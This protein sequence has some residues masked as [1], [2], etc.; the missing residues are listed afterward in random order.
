[1]RTS[2]AAPLN[3]TTT[4]IIEDFA[5]NGSLNMHFASNTSITPLGVR[6]LNVSRAKLEALD[7]PIGTREPENALHRGVLVREAVRSAWASV[8]SNNTSQLTDWRSTNALGL[9][10]VTEE[11]EE[12]FDSDMAEERWL[13][14]VLANVEQADEPYW[15]EATVGTPDYED[16]DYEY[17]EAESYTFPSRA[18]GADVTVVAVSDLDADDEYVDSWL[19]LDESTWQVKAPQY[20]TRSEEEDLPELSPPS[21]ST[22]SSSSLPTPSPRPVLLERAAYEA[23]SPPKKTLYV[24]ED[25]HIVFD[26][27][28][29]SY[30]DFND[31]LDGECAEDFIP[32]PL[33]KCDDSSYRF[34]DD[35]DDDCECRTPPLMPSDCSELEEVASGKAQFAWDRDDFDETWAGVLGLR[36]AE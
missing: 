11:D 2:A 3:S 10:A 14:D 30:N 32:P 27:Y 20:S 7:L 13:D 4:T 12:D 28:D 34:E 19:E 31:C 1:M 5:I 21:S 15:I 6:L 24:T 16:E 22:S 29:D 26:F 18:S 8:E 33:D 35:D 25:D 9:D 17:A 36:I 23:M